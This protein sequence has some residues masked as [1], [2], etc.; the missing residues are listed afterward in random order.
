MT[1]LQKAYCG[2]AVIG[3]LVVG[4]FS[5]ERITGQSLNLSAVHETG[6]KRSVI[7]EGATK[8]PELVPHFVLKNPD[9]KAIDSSTWQ[10]QPI[11]INFWASWCAPCR[12]E[13]PLLN[14][15]AQHPPVTNLAVVGIAVDF[16]DD[17]AK[18][19]K[20]T[21][22]TYSVLIG[23][24]N[25]L[26]LAHNLGVDTMAFPF[27]VLADSQGHI[28]AVRVGELHERE[29]KQALSLM[30]ALENHHLSLNE[31]RQQIRMVLNQNPN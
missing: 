14:Q 1:P 22:I 13:I 23:E 3:A 7:P 5:Y 28:L 21:P 6:I 11:L 16:A 24:E 2:F 8:V 20:T 9:A 30:Q 12:H 10:G 18:F 26:E 15:I 19:M 25:G 31:A 29:L 17:V 27:S 4:A